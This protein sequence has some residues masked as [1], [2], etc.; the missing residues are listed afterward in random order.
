MWSTHFSSAIE[1]ILPKYE[2]RRRVWP[3]EKLE[4]RA[5]TLKAVAYFLRVGC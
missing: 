5:A 1:Q 4:I 2:E 3:E